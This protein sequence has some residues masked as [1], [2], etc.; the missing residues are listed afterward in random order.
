[1]SIGGMGAMAHIDAGDPALADWI[2]RQFR[3]STGAMLGAISATHLVKERSGFFQRV[4]PKKGSVLASPE[5]ASYDPDP[6]YFFHWF[7][8]GA[9]VID[10]LRVLIEAEAVGE[11]GVERFRDFLQFSLDLTSLRGSAYL[12][13]TLPRPSAI[14]AYQQFLRPDAE[15][16]SIGGEG[17]LAETRVNADGTLD[18]IKWTRPQA[19]GSA[20]RA[21]T[22]LRA[23]DMR[24]VDDRDRRA[25]EMLIRDDLA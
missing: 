16:A 6:D 7:R 13:G 23:W 12:D 24:C 14:P 25:M 3:F 1:M 21:L 18:F 11:E 22:H 19:D 15:L 8:D 20:L 9:L 17:V 5:R 4:V 2:E 10:A